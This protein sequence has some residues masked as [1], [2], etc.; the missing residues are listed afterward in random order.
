METARDISCTQQVVIVPYLRY[1]DLNPARLGFPPDTGPKGY[2]NDCT[3][4][5]NNCQKFENNV[6]NGGTFRP[7]NDPNVVVIKAGL[8]EYY[9]VPD[10]MI[11]DPV[12]MAYCATWNGDGSVT[13]VRIGEGPNRKEISNIQFWKLIYDPFGPDEEFEIDPTLNCPDVFVSPGIITVSAEQIAPTAAVVLGQ[14]LDENGVTVEYHISIEPTIV[15][16]QRWELLQKEKTACIEGVENTADYMEHAENQLRL[17]NGWHAT[18]RDVYGCKKAKSLT[19]ELV[20]V[21]P[22]ASLTLT[23]GHGSRANWQRRILARTCLTLTGASHGS[24]MPVD[25][26]VCNIDFTSPSGRGSGLV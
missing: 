15:Q 9:F 5:G 20:E 17:P 1:E 21:H 4:A 7:T 14:D 2:Q 10:W 25:G 26:R 22:G 6:Q 13:I 18:F 3:K 24:R 12:T 11:C 8:G 19:E 16:Y 23:R